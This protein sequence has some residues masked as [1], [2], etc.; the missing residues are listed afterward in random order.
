MAICSSRAGSGP[1]SSHHAHTVTSSNR[2][3]IL[4]LCWTAELKMEVCI[5]VFLS[6]HTFIIARERKCIAR[7]CKTSVRDAKSVCVFQYF[8]PCFMKVRGIFF[9]N[10]FVHPWSFEKGTWFCAILCVLLQYFCVI[11]HKYFPSPKTFSSLSIQ[12]QFLKTLGYFIIFYL[13]SSLPQMWRICHHIVFWVHISVPHVS[14]EANLQQLWKSRRLLSQLG[15]D[16]ERL[17]TDLFLSEQALKKTALWT[18]CHHKSCWAFKELIQDTIVHTPLWYT[19]F[20]CAFS[21]KHQKR[22]W[23]A[24][25]RQINKYCS[26]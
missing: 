8:Q 20:L 19:S 11:L 4:S 15:A 23:N 14:A 26:Q 21:K 1:K 16:D 5:V 9:S 3:I 25:N 12:L 13:I 6:V 17:R 7:D 24:T 10:P 22:I 18:L 2:S